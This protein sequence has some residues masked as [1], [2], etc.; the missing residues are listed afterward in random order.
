[1]DNIKVQTVVEG[2]ASESD[3]DEEVSSIMRNEGQANESSQK[4]VCANII[5]SLS[6]LCRPLVF[7]E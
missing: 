1:M 7:I 2:E 6:V 5:V 3:E 4:G